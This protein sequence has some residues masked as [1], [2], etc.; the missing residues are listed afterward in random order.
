MLFHTLS[1][2]LSL[3]SECS[4]L[5]SRNIWW[6]NDLF[7]SFAVDVILWLSRVVVLILLND[8]PHKIDVILLCINIASGRCVKFS[9]FAFSLFS[10]FQFCVAYIYSSRL[11]G[12]CLKKKTR[13]IFGKW[14]NNKMHLLTHT[15]TQNTRNQEFYIPFD[16]FRN[17]FDWVIHSLLPPSLSFCL[18]LVAK[19]WVVMDLFENS[20]C[21]KAFRLYK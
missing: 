7:L 14:N 10:Q 5:L 9:S 2:S 6:K 17:R 13:R 20:K 8:F 15:Q 4:S 12:V 21:L 11:C 16:Q 19:S 3:S 1:L 18:S